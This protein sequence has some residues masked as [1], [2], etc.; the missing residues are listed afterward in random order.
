[1]RQIT[2]LFCFWI[3]FWITKYSRFFP[4]LW[5]FS[6]FFRDYHEKFKF[7][8]CYLVMRTSFEGISFWNSPPPFS[9]WFHTQQQKR[10][11][12]ERDHWWIYFQLIQ[13]NCRMLYVHRAIWRTLLYL[14]SLALL[15]DPSI[16]F[17]SRLTWRKN[18]PICIGPISLK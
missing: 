10:K 11:I 15:F 14:D 12:N 5:I 3:L 2:M 17:C 18:S 13:D 16:P 7:R 1:M 8:K 9:F 6:S 4:I